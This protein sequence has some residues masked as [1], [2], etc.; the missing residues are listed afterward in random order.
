M[1]IDFSSRI[2][3]GVKE[4]FPEVT[5]QKCIFHTIQL[6]L[7]GLIKELTRVKNDRLIAHIKEWSRLSRL[8]IAIE[9]D[10]EVSPKLDLA[11]K[12]TLH[13]WKIY[14]ELRICLVKDSTKEIESELYIFS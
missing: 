6:L 13:A 12:D 14:Q 2:E 8:S 7:R 10:Q 3:S 11:F 1:T 9:K 4:V 5:T